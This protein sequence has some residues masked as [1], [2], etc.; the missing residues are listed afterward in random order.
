MLIRVDTGFVG[1][2]IVL[3]ER[4]DTFIFEST[5]WRICAIDGAFEVQ[6]DGASRRKLL[7]PLFA[8]ERGVCLSNMW[9]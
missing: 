6:S 9:C 8:F 5:I 1:I 4:S 2:G 7:V 3:Q